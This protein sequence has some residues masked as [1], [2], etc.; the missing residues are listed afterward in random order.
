MRWL[1]VLLM[2]VSGSG[3][4]I[5]TDKDVCEARANSDLA[6]S[7]ECQDLLGITTGKTPPQT[8]ETDADVDADSDAD[9]DADTDSDTDTD[10]TYTDGS[11]HS[12]TVMTTASTADTGDSGTPPNDTGHTGSVPTGDTSE[13]GGAGDTGSP[14][15]EL[16]WYEDL[17]GDGHG[18]NGS[19]VQQC[20]TPGP[21]W[22]EE[23][24]D[25]NDADADIH[26]GADEFC[27][28]YYVDSN[29]DG[30]ADAGAIDAPTWCEDNDHDAWGSYL[31]AITACTSPFDGTTQ[32]GDCDDADAGMNPGETEIPGDAID[33]DC[34]GVDDLF[35][36]CLEVDPSVTGTV[37][38]Y[39]Y[40]TQIGAGGDTYWVDP[41][42]VPLV[43]NSVPF[44]EGDA[45]SPICGD[46]ALVPYVSGHRLQLLGV[47]NNGGVDESLD[48]VVAG[49]SFTT[50]V[51]EV[52]LGGVVISSCGHDDFTACGTPS[53]FDCTFC[54]MP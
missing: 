48:D 20:D 25:C 52:T 2:S 38:V 46:I 33:Q 4:W 53:D 40:E 1:A 24:T 16:D 19:V 26:P 50:R 27:D 44:A 39:V 35:Q 28:Y 43:P 22:F 5:L 8:T 51:S 18:G 34:D 30:D 17:D 9:T 31:G 3:C 49:V 10:P 21:G 29:C 11:G 14:C 41:T 42:A 45:A 7:Q 15:T 32:C 37:T 54:S 12:G 47:W 6:L 13:T 36:L 23:A